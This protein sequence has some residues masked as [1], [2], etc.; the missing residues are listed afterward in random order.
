MARGPLRPDALIQGG[1]CLLMALTAT[2]VVHGVLYGST[3]LELPPAARALPFVLPLA[4][5]ACCCA[6]CGSCML[7]AGC[8]GDAGLLS[9][10]IR[11]DLP[12]RDHP[13]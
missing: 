13:V 12:T 8:G 5:C 9:A 1:G 6:A 4:G 11:C 10:R 7:W 3:W 2:F